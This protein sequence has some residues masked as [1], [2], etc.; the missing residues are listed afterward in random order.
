MSFP[1]RTKPLQVFKKE[2]KQKNRARIM[3]LVVTVK[4]YLNRRST[5]HRQIPDASNEI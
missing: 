5:L 4:K 1:R 2:K 3:V